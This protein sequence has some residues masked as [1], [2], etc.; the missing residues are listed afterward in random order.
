M[1]PG[2]FGGEVRVVRFV[3]QRTLFPPTRAVL[4]GG[5]TVYKPD[6]DLAPCPL[7][8]SLS[9]RERPVGGAG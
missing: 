6:R 9:T 5:S 4:P 3:A 1:V 8:V 7:R 2:V